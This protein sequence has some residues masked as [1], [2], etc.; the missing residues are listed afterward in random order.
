MTLLSVM[1]IMTIFAIV[2]LA[3]APSVYI[4]SQREKELE[5]I[6]RG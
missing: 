1:A 5:A 4:E 6:R 3:A 2:M